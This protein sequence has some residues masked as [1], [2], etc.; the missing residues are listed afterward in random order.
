[1]DPVKTNQT[2]ETDK[3]PAPRAKKVLN[4]AGSCSG[5]KHIAFPTP[6]PPAGDAPER[7]DTGSRCCGG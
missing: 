7:T 5:R 3:A 2:D 4:A 6:P 1:M